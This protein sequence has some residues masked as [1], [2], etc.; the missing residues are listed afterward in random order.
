MQAGQGLETSVTCWQ[1]VYMSVTPSSPAPQAAGAPL[2]V[3]LPQA[4]LS[5]QHRPLRAGAVYRSKQQGQL[6]ATW[7]SAVHV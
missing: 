2:A 3:H 6:S 4:L 1:A 7:S 5:S